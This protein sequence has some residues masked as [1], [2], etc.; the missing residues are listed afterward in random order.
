MKARG[1]GAGG[2]ESLSGAKTK[3]GSRSRAQATGSRPASRRGARSSGLPRFTACSPGGRPGGLP[4]SSLSGAQASGPFHFL[5]AALGESY[6]ESP[7]SSAPRRL[8]GSG[9]AAPSSRL[10]ART[11][12]KPGRWGAGG[13]DSARPR[14]RAPPPAAPFR[15]PGRS[16]PASPPPL[17]PGLGSPRPRPAALVPIRPGLPLSRPR[18]SRRA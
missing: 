13:L 10:A 14:P 11:E 5:G 7:T 4:R 15:L 16:T 2:P 12:G 1:V 18:S 9:A 17:P 3:S 8:C 6:A